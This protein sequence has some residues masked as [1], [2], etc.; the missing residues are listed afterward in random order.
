[1]VFMDGSNIFPDVADKELVVPSFHKIAAAIIHP[2][3]L[4]RAYIYTTERKADDARKVHGASCF[5]GCRL[6]Y[7]H[8]STR[9]N[10]S[11]TEKGV[12]TLLA[13]DLIYH[14]AMK[15]IKYAVVVSNDTDFVWPLKRV[16]DFGCGTGVLSLI[17]KGNDVLQN[18]CDVYTFWDVDQLIQNGLAERAQ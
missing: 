16:E 13:S 4:T 17:K 1:M 5:D 18:A 3:M 7:G 6:V 10:G 12:D 2:R 9:A 11:E 15:N 14:A 8:V